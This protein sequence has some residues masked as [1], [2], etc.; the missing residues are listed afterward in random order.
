[1]HFLVFDE[2]RVY[3]L[4]KETAMPVF[5]IAAGLLLVLGLIYLVMIFPAQLPPRQRAVFANRSYAHRGLF[6]NDAGR[7]ENSLAAFEFAMQHGFG[8]ELDVQF[9]KDRQLI[10]FH[11][12][13]LLR[14][15]G[16]DKNVWELTYAELAAC[17]LFQSEERVP[18][19]REV[20][21]CVAGR[22][23][24]IVEIKAEC[25][26]TA[27]YYELCA[28]THAMLR[29]YS[30][31]YCVESF[32]PLVVRW[33]YRH[34]RDVVRGQLVNGMRHNTHLPRLA[35]FSAAQLLTNALNRPHFIAYNEQD[36]NWALRLVQKLGAMTVLWT[37]RTPERFETLRA[38][39]DAL[40]FDHFVPDLFLRQNQTAKD[41]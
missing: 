6:D 36:R 34:A 37:V 22:E 11:D 29:D 23:P 32:H 35:A 2:I 1:M 5:F 9:T 21:D 20:L 30:G 4:F 33:F 38:T 26:N 27:W 16:V 14:T 7:P 13:D 31:P 12:N 39:E 19:F 10:V 40:I 18:L 41:S 28:A 24:L 25:L 17:R 3:P 15:C 8:C